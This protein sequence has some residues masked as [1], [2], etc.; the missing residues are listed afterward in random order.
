MSLRIQVHIVGEDPI[1]LDV[2]ELPDPNHSYVIGMNPQ[3]RDL[4]E[5][6]YINNEVDTIIIPMHRITLIQVLPSEIDDSIETFV[7][8]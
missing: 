3:R 4:S 2:E 1:V 8:E 5:V 7:R 6:H